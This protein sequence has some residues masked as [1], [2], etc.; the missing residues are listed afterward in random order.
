[1]SD[2]FPHGVSIKQ[3]QTKFGEIIKVGIH[4]EKIFENEMNGQYV[5][6]DIKKAKSGKWYAQNNEYKSQPKQEEINQDE[7]PF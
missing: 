1:M 2:N 3:V 5:N 7:I 6:F 4:T